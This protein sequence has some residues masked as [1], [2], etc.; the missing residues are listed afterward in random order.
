MFSFTR[1]VCFLSFLIFAAYGLTAQ[2][3]VSPLDYGLAFASHEVTKD[4]RTSLNLSPDGPF[5]IREDF[6]LK[7]DISYQRLTNA[8]GYILRIIAN[9]SLNIDLVSSPEHS[10]FH[11]LNLIIKDSPIKLHYD[12]DEIHMKPEEWNQVSIALSFKSNRIT[13]SWNGNKKVMDF[14]TSNLEEFNFLFG[15]NDFGKF[16]TADVPPV[17][18]RNIEIIQSKKPPLKF[19][20]KKHGINTVYD[21]KLERAAVTKNPVWLIDRHVRWIHRKE[22]SINKYPS[23]AFD[24]ASGLLYIADVSSLYT[25]DIKS[26]NTE[27]I[28]NA[29]GT[30]IHTD[31]NQLL[32]V[33]ETGE[34]VNYDVFTNKLAR[35]N[36]SQKSWNNT[37]T[38]FN[39]PRYGHNN[40]FY[41]PFDSALYTFGGYGFFSYSN[42]FYKFDRSQG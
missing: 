31:A 41:N 13:L 21:T 12:F 42:A 2:K 14:P 34:L 17:S 5:R 11:D 19:E 30:V 37:D 39:E 38:T 15:A 40:K 1:R 27:K 23:V 35:Y 25:L 8:F 20:L 7:F 16:N 18:L 9:D 22:I 28:N 3:L 32:Y 24:N 36:F 4:Q 10:E 6:E 26:G 33:D 29:K